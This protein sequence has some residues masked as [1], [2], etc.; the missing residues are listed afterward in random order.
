MDGSESSSRPGGDLVGVVDPG[1]SYLEQ[2]GIKG[3]KWGIR[4]DPAKAAAKAEK[5]WEKKAA[6][7]HRYFK[8]YDTAAEQMNSVR[9]PRLNA[10]PEYK[11]IDV[12]KPGRLT[13]KY[14][15][16]YAKAFNQEIDIASK[17]LGADVNPGGTKRITYR[18]GKDL[19]ITFGFEEIK[20]A[21]DGELAFR[22]QLDADG[23]IISFTVVNSVLQQSDTNEEILEH[24]GIKG[25][26]WGVR[27]SNPSAEPSSD[28]A[29]SDAA[30]SKLR[31]DGLKALSNEELQTVVTR[32]NL[33]QNFNKVRPRTATE[34]TAKFM[35]DLLLQI[36]KEEFNKAARDAAG[37]A[38]REA[39]K[40]ALKR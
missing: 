9:I 24:F 23:R 32:L 30:V 40:V 36:G 10:K 38:A 29:R 33:E 5:K 35:R 17:N 13:D 14:L 26:K 7:T 16:D 18:M 34:K 1:E 28:A 25:M 21:D 19:D 37:S 4:R 27:R 22:A 6:S 15:S 20:H 11:N 8:A 12:R 2:F 31:K 39:L 3:M